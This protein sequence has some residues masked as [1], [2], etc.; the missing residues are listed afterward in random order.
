MIAL[1]SSE[2]LD[3]ADLPLVNGMRVSHKRS[4]KPSD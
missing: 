3:Q 1:V 2:L 4:S